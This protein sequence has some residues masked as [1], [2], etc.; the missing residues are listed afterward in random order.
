MQT[1]Q[2][3]KRLVLLATLAVCLMTVVRAA[4]PSFSAWQQSRLAHRLVAD[5]EQAKDPNSRILLRQVATLGDAAI[6]ALVEAAASNRADVSLQA[7]QIIEEKLGTWIATSQVDPD[8]DLG[9]PSCLL[10][11]ALAEHI[12]D[13][14]SLGQ[15]WSSKLTLELVALADRLPAE[16][17][18]RILADCSKILEQVPPV[19]PLM[20]TVDSV[21]SSGSAP[22][23]AI[24]MG[25]QPDL[26]VLNIPSERVISSKPLPI[27]LP[28]AESSENT[29]EIIESAEENLRPLPSAWAT[30]QPLTSSPTIPAP[31]ASTLKAVQEFGDEPTQDK[32]VTSP[33]AIVELPT[34]DEMESLVAE[35]SKETTRALAKELISADFYTAGAIRLVLRERG[36]SDEERSLIDRLLSSE[37][38]D[39]LRLVRDLEVLPARPA[40][41][42]LRELLHDEN[43]EVRLQALTALATSKDPELVDFARD[44]AVRDRDARVSELAARIMREAR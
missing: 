29:P 38:S 37:V 2:L 21:S 17:A 41:Q 39:R 34:P 36:I 32:A 33:G 35:L 31:N 6:A 1:P 8:F 40:R 44:M 3:I 15:Q 25:R 30:N 16:A 42:W 11:R 13:F 26:S 23:P 24:S 7:R 10:A 22:A 43:A 28:L 14:G 18:A 19:G 20:R 4:W 27:A 12:S 5:M 9:Q